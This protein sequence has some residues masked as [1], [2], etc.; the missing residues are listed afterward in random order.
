MG[1]QLISIIIP[2]YNVEKYVKECVARIIN[3]T[4]KNIEILL[5]DDGATDHSGK[6]CDECAEKD[7]RI[8]VIHKE[9]GGVSSA[10]NLG[11]EL[12]Q[13]E[14][15]TFVDADD[16]VAD[17]YL[18]QLY[19]KMQNSNADLV[20]CKY[21]F[22]DEG[23]IIQSKETFPEQII[24]DK[25][26]KNFIN[27]I[28]RFFT[29]NRKK[30]IMGSSCRVLY[31]KEAINK[32]LFNT[33]LRIAEDLLF[34]VDVIL[35]AHIVSFINKNLYFYRI[36]NNSALHSSY[37]KDYLNNQLVLYRELKRLLKGL[38]SKKV[39]KTMERYGA[40]L[41]YVLFNNELNAK[42]INWRENVEKIRES[43]L[44]RYFTF[45]NGLS[46]NSVKKQIKFFLV[47]FLIKTRLV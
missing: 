6:I 28:C 47:W 40:I 45:K 16:F 13:G 44:Y 26:D 35:N 14:Y 9:N 27:F 24:V 12:A 5:I 7:T 4:Y 46:L 29:W 10:R 42:P 18:E 36:N 21:A 32:S 38:H 25:Q 3:Q 41:C 23:T 31:K 8:K 15:I 37:K 2:V 39:N 33:Q 1:D 43:E 20:F 11:L 19:N 30:N 22:F 34:L 17:D